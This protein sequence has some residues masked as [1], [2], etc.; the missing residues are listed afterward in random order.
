MESEYLQKA[1]DTFFLQE[2]L[3]IGHLEELRKKY[4]GKK[5]RHDN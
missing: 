3:L 5:R 1:V 2:N 4:K